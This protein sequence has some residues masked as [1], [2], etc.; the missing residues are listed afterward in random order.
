MI[1]IITCTLL[2]NIKYSLICIMSLDESKLVIFILQ[3]TK[4]LISFRLFLSF[5]LIV[6]VI[7]LSYEEKVIF[8]NKLAL[9]LC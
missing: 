6:S 5:F 4:Y 7:A 2:L 8:F 1:E 3:K 9:D